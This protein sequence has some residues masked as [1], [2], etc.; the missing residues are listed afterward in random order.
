MD[1][2]LYRRWDHESKMSTILPLSQSEFLQFMQGG[3]VLGQTAKV[4]ESPKLNW[5]DF[6]ATIDERA[7]QEALAN[8]PILSADPFMA[9]S[10][11]YKDMPSYLNKPH[12]KK[13][14]RGFTHDRKIFRD[15]P[16]GWQ[17]D[18]MM[19]I[20]FDRVVTAANHPVD[21]HRGAVDDDMRTSSSYLFDVPS[22]ILN[23]L[24]SQKNILDPL[25]ITHPGLNFYLETKRLSKIVK[26]SKYLRYLALIFALW[27]HRQVLM[28]PIQD[29]FRETLEQMA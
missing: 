25:L 27:Y 18:V 4:K 8:L 26:Q 3:F 13:L 24:A 19:N 20:G 11:I 5:A 6:T 29:S 15:S 12:P 9:L 10:S 2:S 22:E 28:L 14:W 17:N 7:W 1:E 23:Y 21:K 16:Y